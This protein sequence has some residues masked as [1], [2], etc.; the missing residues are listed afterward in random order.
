MVDTT[1]LVEREHEQE[2]K[3]GHR[4]CGKYVASSP[5]YIFVCVKIH[6]VYIN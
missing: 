6:F 3:I 5:V 4:F 2:K 1:P